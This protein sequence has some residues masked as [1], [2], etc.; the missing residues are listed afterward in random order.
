MFKT[1]GLERMKTIVDLVVEFWKCRR[2][3]PDLMMKHC[4]A[5][6]RQLM[7]AYLQIDPKFDSERTSLKRDGASR[8]H[9]LG[10]YPWNACFSI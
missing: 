4:T 6:R 5:C 7:F 3:P 9:L 8:K 10:H 2:T 1:V